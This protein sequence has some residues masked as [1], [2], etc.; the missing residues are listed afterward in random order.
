M[1]FLL[2]SINISKEKGTAKWA[3]DRA[4]LKKAV[5]IVGDAHKGMKNREISLLAREEI[6]GFKPDLKDG[7]FGENFTISGLDCSKVK[8]LDYL[9]VG[10][11][12]LQIS[13]IGKE[14][15]DRCHIFKEMGDCIMPK[16]GFFARVLNGG[17][18][19]AGA[20]AVFIPKSYKAVIITLSDRASKN[21][22]KDKS[23]EVIVT[24]LAKHFEGINR[25]IQ[26]EKIVIPDSKWRLAWL[27]KKFLFKKYDFIITTG[28]TGV[29][30]RD[31]T[32]DVARKYVK[33]ELSGIT[34]FIRS[35]YGVLNRNALISRSVVGVNGK[36]FIACLPGSVNAVTEYMEEMIPMFSHIFCMLY[37]VDH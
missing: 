7:S 17:I 20:Q 13:K 28:G 34:E 21:I 33:K 3:V 36:T 12:L 15:H 22:Y 25:K 27:F 35:K 6:D 30:Q 26:I 11:S 10:K 16:K 14:C 23:G 32:I 19:K 29:G 37:D 31:I 1:K 18:I 5:G 8:L 9:K 24:L 4:V 2:K